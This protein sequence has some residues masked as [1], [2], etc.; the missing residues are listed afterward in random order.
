MVVVG[1]GVAVVTVGA[2][3]KVMAV[4]AGV[5]VVAAGAGVVGAEVVIA[6]DL[7]AEVVGTGVARAK[8]VLSVHCLGSWGN[9]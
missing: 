8:V 7:G 1:A 4:G 2:G 3:D 5:V 9:G 6:I